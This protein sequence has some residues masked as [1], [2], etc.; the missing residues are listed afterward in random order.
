MLSMKLRQASL[1]IDVISELNFQYFPEQS[2]I[3]LPTTLSLN[4]LMYYL[5]FTLHS[6]AHVDKATSLL[7][8]SHYLCTVISYI[9]L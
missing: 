7:P 1:I 6:V 3:A 2:I 5:L 9:T 4:H 8:I